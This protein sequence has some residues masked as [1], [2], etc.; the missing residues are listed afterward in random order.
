M[1]IYPSI[2]LDFTT[3]VS[4]NPVAVGELF[5]LTL[6]VNV[7]DNQDIN[8]PELPKT[9]APFELIGTHTS[10]QI[11][12]NF[13][14]YSGSSK[15]ITKQFIYTLKSD[16]EG[17]WNIDPITIWMNNT[18]HKTKPIQIEV[19]SKI[20]K[21]P[22]TRKS[23]SNLFDK[24]NDIFDHHSFFSIPKIRDTVNQ[25]SFQLKTDLADRNIYIGEMLPVQWNIYKKLNTPSR[26]FIEKVDS[27]QPEDFW[28]EKVK[29][30]IHLSFNK[31]VTLNNTTYQ[32]ALLFSYILFP[33]KTGVLKI[34]SITAQLTAQSFSMFSSNT[35]KLKSNPISIQVSPLPTKGKGQ[36]TG[37]VGQFVITNEVNQTAISKNDIL[38]YKIHFKGIGNIQNIQLPNWPENEN[39]KVYDTLE[40]Q[41][42]SVRNSYKTYEVLLLAKKSGVLKTPVINWTTFD[43]ELESYVSH[44]LP[45]KTIEVKIAE[46]QK[47]NT[48]QFFKNI[49]QTTTDETKPPLP[50]LTKQHSFYTKYKRWI[51]IL[52]YLCIFIAIVYKNKF[53]KF[54]LNRKEEVQKVMQYSI[55]LARK[56][57]DQ[58][59]Y[60]KVGITLLDLV[61]KL[62]M[63]LTGTSGREIEVLLK[64]CPPSIQ[65]EISNDLKNF[66]H[67]I[68][69]LSFAPK[70]THQWSKQE[71]IHLI[72]KGQTLVI[73]ILTHYQLSEKKKH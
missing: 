42:F 48:E 44:E 39:F 3:K 60:Q 7:K 47:Q 14:N 29:N 31:E 15:N 21:S 43:P 20:K 53:W 68:E 37:A 71:I 51:W 19:S 26:V 52:I 8:T 69:M 23:P 16:K 35:L 64:K 65:K 32:K 28:I 22:S 24:F 36:F 13:S 18:S 49:E 40:S 67:T 61:D 5:D 34:P 2:A 46:D 11:S 50:I 1:S 17:V 55:K 6:E 10:T 12:V 27:I 33:L 45:S 57:A 66:I 25:D 4:K 58:E 62:W 56:Q 30:T 9:I 73:K 63:V 72:E 41:K 70:Q 38:S 59:Q 54:R